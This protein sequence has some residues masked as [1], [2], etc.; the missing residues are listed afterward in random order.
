MANV[1]D[2]EKYLEVMSFLTSCRSEL[3]Y[4]ATELQ[5][6]AVEC[7]DNI[8]DD[9]VRKYVVSIGKSVQVYQRICTLID[10][11]IRAMGRELKNSQEAAKKIRID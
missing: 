8:N 7:M 6:D 3:E 11:I 9:H 10:E 5:Y 2:E 1:I 4:C